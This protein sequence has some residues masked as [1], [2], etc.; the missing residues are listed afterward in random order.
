MLSAA[1]PAGI[2]P[3]VV[4]VVDSA[5][6]HLGMG[7][8]DLWLPGDAV[9]RDAHRLPVVDSLFQEPLRTLEVVQR[10]A[11][12][13][14]ELRPSSVD[15]CARQWFPLL[16]FGE[17]VPQ[18]YEQRLSAGQLDSLLGVDLER[19]V[20]LIAATSL[21]QYLAPLVQ[22]WRDIEAARAALIRQGILLEFA[23]S[24]LLLSEDDP[25]ATLFE[26]KAREDYALGRARTFFEAAAHVSWGRFLAPMVSLWRAVWATIERNSPP[27][28][29]YR[30]SVRTVVLQTP[31]GRI[32]IGGPGDDTYE[33]DFTFIL[34]V[35]GND[36]YIMPPRTKQEAFAQPIR[37]IIDL[38]GDDAYQGEDFAWGAG[39]FGCGLLYDLQGNDVYRARHFSL[40]SAIGGLGVLFDGAGTDQY[41]GGIHVQGAAAFGLGLLVDGGGNDLYQCFAQAQGFGF[42]RGYGVIYD[43]A[44][45]DSY[46]AQSPYVDVLRYEQ[47]YLS[48]TQGAALGYRP[49]ASGGI[50]MLVDSSGN[51]L[52]ISDIY[53][54]GTG[55][56][57]ALGALVD[58]G[59]EDRY[60]S[61][62]YAQG[63]GVHLAFGLLWDEAGDDVYVSHGVSQGCGHDIA[64]GVLYDA[65]GDDTYVCESLSQGAANANGIALFLDM[66]GA[67]SYQA[68]VSNTQ[69]YGNFRRSYGSIGIFADA[70]GR[71]WY[72]DTGAN[73]RVRVGS[74]YGVLL[75]EELVPPAPPQPRPG[76]DVPDSLRMPL[77]GSLDSLFVQASAAPQKFQYIVAP[78]RERIAAFGAAALPFLAARFS[79]ESAR[80]RLAL[81]A[82]LPLIDARDSAALRRLVLDSLRS[83]NERTLAL[84][85]T[86][87]GRLRLRAAVPLLQELLQ[88]QRWTIR[89][90]AAQ[91]LGEVGDLRAEAAL[92]AALGDAHRM[93]RARAAYALMQL[94]PRQPLELWRQALEDTFAV[95]RYGAVQG[96]LQHGRLPLSL[97]EELWR[98][99]LSMP[100]RLAAAWL[101]AGLDTLVSPARVGQ[102]LLQ[103]PVEVRRMAYFALPQ[104][105]TLWVQRL[106]SFCLR[107]EPVG[108]L[109]RLLSGYP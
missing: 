42:V 78:A 39:F 11:R 34:D 37:I 10:E 26:L 48:F 88:D 38:S 107:R 89:A 81:E 16:E 14:A 67:D 30:D 68:R 97:L 84:M 71:D 105:A 102:L 61:Y 60:V 74:T 98:L 20:G 104:Q 27:L 96:A 31:F 100:G 80:E 41:L 92:R 9:P 103:Q 18:Y 51:D 23:D 36:R 63:A 35:G 99:P 19:R 86:V 76:I 77:A 21:R 13:L 79:T 91:R 15:A 4:R 25:K 28:D 6:A 69:G 72:A 62:Q 29:R 33:G 93:V 95:V 64:L 94:R 44:G 24:L 32:A 65:G 83:S 7:R 87:A 66:R 58:W 5:L 52:Y 85:G 57:Y 73:R 55:Y 56:W 17:Y 43:R 54:Q 46:L 2:V 53:G 106:R 45:N 40:G 101:V 59:G 75:D 22:A 108:E 109:R 12:V 1:Q 70:E 3:E 47:H 49:L 8:H 90:M 82:I 50:G